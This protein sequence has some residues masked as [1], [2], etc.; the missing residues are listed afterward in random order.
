MKPYSA[1]PGPTAMPCW[2]DMYPEHASWQ[3]GGG[4]PHGTD[5]LRRRTGPFREGVSTHFSHGGRCWL[6]QTRAM[7][8][9]YR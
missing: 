6:A 3:P 2:A 1:E 7:W 9:G 5:P 4:V 8:W